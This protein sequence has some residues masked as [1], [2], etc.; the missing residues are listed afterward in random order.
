LLRNFP[1]PRTFELYFEFQIT[2]ENALAADPSKDPHFR[3]DR[4]DKMRV[5]KDDELERYRRTIERT[6]NR[7]WAA[8]GFDQS[9]NR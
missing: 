4:I 9:L 7:Q 2:E 6:A 5:Q 1:P 8:D 3:E